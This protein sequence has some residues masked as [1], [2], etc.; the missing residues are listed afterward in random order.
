MLHPDA[1]KRTEEIHKMA[2]LLKKKGYRE[3][4]D[5]ILE[6]AE[7]LK[8]EKVPTDFLKKLDDLFN[9]FQTEFEKL[10]YVGQDFRKRCY[11]E[12]KNLVFK[13]IGRMKSDFAQAILGLYPSLEVLNHGKRITG[14]IANE[15]SRKHI[16]D[17][18]VVF[19]L[20]CFAFL[21]EVEGIFDELARILYF[22]E[23]VDKK[24]IP[25]SQE[26]SNMN[27]WKV[28]KGFKTP[29]VFLENW[30]EKKSIRNAIGHAN[31]FYDSSKKEARF[32][33]A[34][35]GYDKI[36]TV[37]QF[38]E[39]FLQLEDSVSAFTYIM[40]LLKLYDLIVSE[41]PFA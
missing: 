19:H 29:P 28:L 5:K 4:A 36:L 14:E 10:P 8:E 27:A 23:V 1:E 11:E 39:I 38:M 40:I 18:N 24:K 41:T 37:N 17:D 32:I 30:A 12:V 31:V 20:Y 25:T 13:A 9:L 26:L 33:N 16:E 7:I 3:T 15:L 34:P 2:E 22:F 35:A 21:I 6:F